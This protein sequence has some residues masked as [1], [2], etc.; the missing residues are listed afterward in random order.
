MNRRDFLNTALT[1]AVASRAAQPGR[2]PNIVLFLYDDL[3]Y[4]G[5]GCYG[6]QKIRTPHS[7]RLAVEGARW[8]DCYAGAPVC[9]PSRSVLMSG[10]HGGHAP[11]R[12]NAQTIPLLPSD[13]TV[14]AMLQQ[15]GYKT[16]AFGK[17]GLGDAD[18]TGSPVR[19][20]FDEFFGYTHQ[21][22]AHNYWPEYLRDGDK[23]VPLPGNAGGRK[24]AYASDLIADSMVS[25]VDRHHQQPFFLF[26]SITL[27]HALFHPPSDKPYSSQ[28]WTQAQKDYAAMVTDADGQLGR[29]L[30]RLEHHKLS[31]DTMVVCSSDNGGSTLPNGDHE[32]FETN[33]PL[34]DYKGTVYEGGIRAP[35]I[36]RWPGHTQPGRVSS[37]PWYFADFLPTVASFAGFA[38]PSGIDG[39]SMRDEIEGKPSPARDARFMY[40]EQNGWSAKTRELVPESLQQGVRHGDWKAVRKTP[41]TPLELYD[42][43]KDAGESNNIAAGS[44]Q[45]IRMIEDY[46]KTARTQPRTHSNGNPEW[47][48][49]KDLPKT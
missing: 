23:K 19:K 38:A 1:G 44:P 34:R 43:K 48:G 5:L 30:E 8:T 6:Q 36:V 41:G 9:A 16:G 24:G 47:V 15:A 11:V 28:P 18:T 27:P 45:T 13:R 17:W 42:L 25:F 7:D 31:G 10:Q 46:L 33:G 22:H 37:T 21:T 20:G 32:F 3:G 2:R 4:G 26:A 12:A 40:W 29:I 39:I 14:A 49:R 35:M